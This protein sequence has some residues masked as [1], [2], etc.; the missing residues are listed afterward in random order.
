MLFEFWGPRACF[1]RPELKVERFTYCIPTPAALKGMISAIYWHPGIEWK[2]DK[3]YVLNPIRYETLK[4]N[5]VGKIIPLIRKADDVFNS[6]IM[7]NNKDVRVQRSSRVLVDVHYVVDAHF[8][9]NAD[10]AGSN[11]TPDKIVAIIARRLEKGQCF[12]TPYLGCREFS[13]SFRRWPEGETIPTI[14]ES[15]DF[16]IMLY[17]LD[18]S[19]PQNIKP[20]Y[21]HAI[22]EQGVIDVNNVEVL[23]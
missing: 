18:Y 8:I 12:N 2:I 21:F 9:M 23:K 1:T 3:I 14:M 15:Q 10:K 17:D 5:E 19:D 13:C 20:M 16:G 22:M 11:D 7:T 6:R 4:R